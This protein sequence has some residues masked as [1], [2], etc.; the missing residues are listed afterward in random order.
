MKL[1]HQFLPIFVVFCFLSVA[2]GQEVDSVDKPITKIG[3]VNGMAS[4]L[5]K[6]VY[7]KLP[8]DMCASG[9]VRIRV[10]I[11]KNGRVK[12]AEAISGNRFLRN[13]AVKAARRARFNRTV[14]APPIEHLGIVIY[15]F[16]PSKGCLK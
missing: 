7:P 4:Y 9:Q 11:G 6:P 13:S 15:N 5:P 12:E 3:V 1:L 10:L 16:P 2:S 14:D 8:I